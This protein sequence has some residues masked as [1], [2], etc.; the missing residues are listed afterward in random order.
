M[1]I[2]EPA[3]PCAAMDKD[4][5]IHQEG[6]T[7]REWFAAMAMQGFLANSYS[8]GTTRPLSTVNRHEI[9]NMAVEQADALMIRLR[10][11]GI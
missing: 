2:N 4:G 10:R 6:L 9:A 5:L 1:K 8:D 7:K 3:F 11:K